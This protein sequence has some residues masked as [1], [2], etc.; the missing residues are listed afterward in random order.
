MKSSNHMCSKIIIILSYV[1]NILAASGN[2]KAFV[3]LIHSFQ[4][5]FSLFLSQTFV[6]LIYKMNQE[7]KCKIKIKEKNTNKKLT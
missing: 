4:H 5:L 1:T 6:F 3:V 2:M 7:Q